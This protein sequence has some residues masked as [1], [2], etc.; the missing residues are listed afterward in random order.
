M[1]GIGTVLN[2]AKLAIAAQQQGLAVTSHNISNVNSPYYSRQT[3]VYSPRDPVSYGHFWLGTGVDMSA[4]QRS[5][6]QLLENRLI[7]IKSDLAS[8]EEM[9]NYMNVFEATLNE[10]S[11]A[12]ISKLMTE[13]WNAWQGVSNNPTGAPERVAVYQKGVEIAQRLDILAND[14]LQIETDVNSEI[15]STLCEIESYSSQIAE[16]NKNLLGQ[17]INNIS[18]D[19]LDQR[20]GLVTELAKLIG[21]STFEQPNG[22]L[23]INTA[24]GFSLVNGTD[25]L[26]LTFDAG[27]ICWEGSCGGQVDITDKITGGKISGWLEMRD[28]VISKYQAELD[29]LAKEFIWTVNYQ[30][31]QGVGLSTFDGAVT[32]TYSPDGSGRLDTLAFGQKID[33]TKDFKMY[34]DESG[35]DLY[36]F[37]TVDM[38]LS[39]ASTTF[40]GMASDVGSTYTITLVDSGTIGGG[41]VDQDIAFEWTSSSTG[42]SGTAT[43]LAGANSITVDGMTVNF[44]TGDLVAGN[45]L[46]VNTSAAGAPAPVMLSSLTGTANGVSD[47]YTFTV[48]SGGNIGTDMITV[49]WAN[50]VTNGSFTLDA[51]T[52]DATV[53]GMAL[54]FAAAGRFATDDVFTITTDSTGSPSENLMG[55]WHWTLDSFTDQFNRD[56]A[57]AGKGVTATISE[58]RITFTPDANSRIAFPGSVTMAAGASSDATLENAGVG[59]LPVLAAGDLTINGISIQAADAGDDT[60]SSTDNAASAIAIA[61]AINASTSTTGVRAY[62]GK[63]ETC[64]VLDGTGTPSIGANE[65]FINGTAIGAVAWAGDLDSTA[66]DLATA[67]NSESSTT[68][69]SASYASATE[70]LTLTSVDGR[71]IE[72]ET[73]GAGAATLMGAGFANGDDKVIRGIVTLSS[74]SDLVIGGT[75]PTVV[76]F[77]A[78]PIA[79]TSTTD[80]GLT[81]ALGINTFFT[82]DD[83]QSMAVNSVLENREYIA[84]ATLDPITGDFGV[85]DN[86]NANRIA[87]IKFMTRSI[88]EWTYR[89]G[90]DAVS[91][92]TSFSLEDYFHRMVGSVG[93][94]SA[95]V[96]RSVTFNE[97]LADKLGEQRDNLSGVSLDEEM[98]NMMKFQQAYNVASKLLTVADE[99]MT[100]LIN[101][102]R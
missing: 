61:A 59:D 47:T 90:S 66:A 98:I 101:T 42:R 21:V 38:D 18:H 74:D 72:I 87:E 79:V 43:M 52:T 50:S 89:R 55:E 54:T 36:P 68:G 10:N 100:T 63:T 15:S 1:S 46:T 76:G 23:T 29:A 39:S 81:A 91:R 60:V 62:A 31:S 9:S 6:D 7:D 35:S 80:S 28:E 5:A 95:N 96:N 78:G 49:N 12:G 27:R 11:D 34:V 82:G 53:D 99:M 22:S 93:V 64:M 41:G 88:A 20:N 16:L 33:Y 58:N 44:G 26:S 92:A 30:H 19:M 24:G 84:A 102:R 13:F 65:L 57:A 45:T 97:S 94:K 4:V 48:T 2:T 14:L 71:N 32:G 40:A 25:A 69:V 67:I 85:G 86:S 75:D 70:T 17:E 37:V 77:S 83:C 56:A 73:A 3:A 8:S 51:T